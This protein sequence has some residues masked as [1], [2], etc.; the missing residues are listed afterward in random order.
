MK[1]V[2]PVIVSNGVFSIQMR[3]AGLHSTSRME[4]EGNYLNRLT[5]ILWIIYIFPYMIGRGTNSLEGVKKLVIFLIRYHI[6]PQEG[7]KFKLKY[8][9]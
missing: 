2:R 6:L 9:F 4:K 3:S 5:S 7:E 1:A 8:E